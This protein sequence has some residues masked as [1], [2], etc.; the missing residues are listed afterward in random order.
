[1]AYEVIKTIKGRQYRYLQETYREGGRVRTRNSYL[2]P[3]DGGVRRR[4]GVTGLLQDLVRKKDRGDF[5]ETESQERERVACEDRERVKQAR[6]NEQLTGATISLGAMNDIAE[7]QTACG[8][9]DV[10][11]D[12]AGGSEGEVGG[13]SPRWVG[14]YSLFVSRAEGWKQKRHEE[15]FGIRQ[16]RVLTVTTSAER[17]QTMVEAVKTMTGG[18]GSNVFL[19]AAAEALEGRSPLELEWTSGKGERVFIVD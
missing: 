2:G 15:Q 14:T 5:G 11:S 12:K 18:A 16:F 4:G 17:V 6:V 1:M 3:L 7:S 9:A 8:K 19:F 10:C 13:A